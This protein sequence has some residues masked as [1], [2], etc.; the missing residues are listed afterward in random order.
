MKETVVRGLKTRIYPTENQ[1]ILI[2][3]TMGCVRLVWNYSLMEKIELYKMFK[4]YPELLQSHK[5]KTPAEWKIYF[6]FLKEVDSQALATTHQELRQAFKNFFKGTHDIPRFKSK[7]NMRS[8]FTSHT[9][10]NN[11]RIVG[12]S[13]RLPKLGLVQMK[14]KRQE[15]PEGAIIKA[16]TVSKSATGKYSV[17]LRIEYTKVVLELSSNVT[18]SIGL[19]F[20]MSGF[21]I[22]QTGKKANYPM[23]LRQSLKKLATEQRKLSKKVRGSNSYKKQRI[24]VAKVHE[25]IK[26]QRLDF[27]H[28]LANRL[29]ENYDLITV[30]KLC[31]QDMQKNKWFSRKI[32]DM[33]YHNFLR[34]LQY[35]AHDYG[36]IFHQVSTY[37]PSSK[38]CSNCGNIKKELPLS[39]RTYTCECGNTINR[40]VNAAY[41]LCIEGVKSFFKEDRTTSIA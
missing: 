7:R 27:H 17:S 9:T 26:N 5:Y 21:Y 2:D 34:I 24:K 32:S 40:D 33:G 23:Y 25:K 12:D 36:K 8:S 1:C 39:Q 4:D 22:D 10:N 28:K 14:K 6:P 41:N 11:I 35:K 15:L 3:K 16:A 19:D 38:K 13:I 29:V 30:E 31:L 37:F 18:T 20:S